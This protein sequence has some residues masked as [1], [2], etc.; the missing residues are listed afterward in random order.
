MAGKGDT[1]RPINLAKYEQNY[2]NIFRSCQSTQELKEPEESESGA[3]NYAT[4]D[5]T[6]DEDSNSAVAQT[7]QM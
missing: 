5:S 6:H 2:N 4:K 7:L 1:P 3:T